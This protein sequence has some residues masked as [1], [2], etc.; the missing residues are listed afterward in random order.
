MKIIG[1]ADDLLS[2]KLFIKVLITNAVLMD[3]TATHVRLHGSLTLLV[4]RGVGIKK[5][6]FKCNS[7]DLV[8]SS[9]P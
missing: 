3:K 1:V 4:L 9:S 5:P 6:L 8:R 7:L 2:A